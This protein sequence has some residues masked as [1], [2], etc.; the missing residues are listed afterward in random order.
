MLA[1]LALLAAATT[2]ALHWKQLQ[3]PAPPRHAS[4][5][6]Q[7]PSYPGGRDSPSNITPESYVGAEACGRCHKENYG[8]W[9]DHPHRRMNQLASDE[10]VLG[11]FAGREIQAAGGVARLEH[12]PGGPFTMTLERAGSPR[13]VY[14][15]TR[16]IGSRFKQFYAGVLVEGQPTGK[17][18]AQD[19]VVLPLGFW[20]QQ[21]RWMPINY[22]DP[23]GDDVD[24]HGNL[25]FD[26]WHPKDVPISKVCAYCH[27]TIP[28]IYRFGSDETGLGF[29]M[30]DMTLDR[31]A[32]R[33]ELARLV[34]LQGNAQ[35]PP[36]FALRLPLDSAVVSVG[37]SCES[38]HFGT[39]E[40]AQDEADYRFGPSSPHLGLQSAAAS[41]NVERSGE[42][43]WLVNGICRQ[44][45]ASDG[46]S[47]PD[48]SSFTNSRES[49]EL[50]RSA[51]ASQIACTDCHD[52]HRAG[53]ADSGGPDDPGQLAACTGCHTQ[54]AETRH[55]QAHGRHTPAQASCLDCHMPRITPGITRAIRSHRISVP[56]D[57][58]MIA[59]GAPSACNLCHADQSIAWTV[60]ELERG[61]GRKG[62]A[63]PT[64]ALAQEARPQGAAIDTW[65]GSASQPTRLVAIDV[66]SR[67]RDRASLAGLLAQLEVTA[68]MTRAYAA[69]A[70]ERR[71]GRTLDLAE[72]DVTAPPE[73]RAQQLEALREK[74]GLRAE[75][76]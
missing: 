62:L 32:L 59:A 49:L 12:T 16:T 21:R 4:T 33:S 66:L 58:Q 36:V 19:E 69:L 65:T 71:L 3:A 60:T 64:S 24:A 61:W 31:P 11:D 37:I 48:G 38:C 52:P 54:Y 76:P 8:A 39:R 63:D 2:A 42:K 74:L 35:F 17:N 26:P 41:E 34:D 5:P 44:C 25:G 28:Y 47:Y 9:L 30:R 29:P 1:G 27:N 50:D 15:V 14:R 72:L 7:V 6:G 70:L 53:P 75:P 73:R 13:R 43:A 51:C 46:E 20:I 45:H 40:H 67:M 57:P 56:G 68:G 22:F 55:A 18:S 10:T 23:Y